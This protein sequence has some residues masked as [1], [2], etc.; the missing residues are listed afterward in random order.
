MSIPGTPDFHHGLLG[1]MYNFG[2]GVREDAREAVRWYRL[3][4]DQGNAEA[5]FSLGLR[6]VT[7]R[8]VPQDDR[9]AVRW[10]R[11]AADQ[12]NAEAQD[13]LERFGATCAT[14]A[15]TCASGSG[16]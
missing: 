7:G 8:G 6:Y 15:G 1:Y 9:E 14:G 2:R 11:L 13:H 16:R 5:Q 3:A 10:W 12:G 4:A